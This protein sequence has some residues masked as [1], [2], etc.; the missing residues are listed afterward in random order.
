M[1]GV[2]DKPLI[3]DGGKGNVVLLYSTY[4]VDDVSKEEADYII[5][6]I[7]SDTFNTG[8]YE[9]VIN[10]KNVFEYELE[11]DHDAYI[12]FGV[13]NDAETHY[14]TIDFKDPETAKE[15]EQLIKE[16]FKN[17]GLTRKEEQMSPISAAIVPLII[18]GVTAII[19]GLITWSSYGFQDWEPS[20]TQIVK[21]YV[22][23]F[24]KISKTVGY[25][26]FLIVSVLAVLFCLYKTF[27]R[28]V[29][30]PFKVTASK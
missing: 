30:P 9:L 8:N 11:L 20:R 28:M 22:Y 18:T 6:K 1:K 7:D 21:W 4:I 15:A 23:L 24:V 26:P 3:L 27:K 14:K 12:T 13:N 17:L 10:V 19:G 16:Q 5:K 29:N 25:L 2:F